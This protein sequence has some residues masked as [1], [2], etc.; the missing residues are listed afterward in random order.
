M[1]DNELVDPGLVPSQLSGAVSETS[2][3]LVRTGRTLLPN[4]PGT[5]PTHKVIDNF[6]SIDDKLIS[7]YTIG[8][9]QEL[10]KVSKALL[11]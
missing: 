11:I 6:R 3:A 8:G 9:V 4:P 7:M 2:A 5:T 10:L 1:P